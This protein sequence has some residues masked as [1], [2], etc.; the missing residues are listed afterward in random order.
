MASRF[1]HACKGANNA[2]YEYRKDDIITIKTKKKVPWG[3]EL[4]VIYARDPIALILRYSFVQPHEQGPPT[5]QRT[6]SQR[7]R[8]P[9]QR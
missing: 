8:R 6:Q 4:T 5:D 2:T 9:F 3:K 1:T 7:K